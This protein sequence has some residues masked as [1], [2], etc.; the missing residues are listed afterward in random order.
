MFN[1]SPFD[2]SGIGPAQIVFLVVMVSSTLTLS[3]ITN[4]VRDRIIAYKEKGKNDKVA[5]GVKALNSLQK[6]I[7]LQL[8]ITFFVSLRI[9]LSFWFCEN[10]SLIYLDFFNVSFAFI[11]FGILW[12]RYFYYH[13]GGN[14]TITTE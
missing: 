3:V 2:I 1:C 6:I 5:L 7:F 10:T 8:G 14:K 4:G 11:T 9:L 13:G 12:P